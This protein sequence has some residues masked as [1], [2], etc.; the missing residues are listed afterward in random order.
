M[1]RIGRTIGGNCGGAPVEDYDPPA[2][3]DLN[4]DGRPDIA[5]TADNRGVGIMYQ[6]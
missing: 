5:F 6:G 2:V 4:G 1:D 3:G